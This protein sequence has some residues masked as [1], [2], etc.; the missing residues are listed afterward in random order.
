MSISRRDV[1]AAGAI[2]AALGSS[3]TSA[4]SPPAFREL[5]LPNKFFAAIAKG[6]L[7]EARKSAH[8]SISLAVVSTAGTQ[9]FDGPDAVTEALNRFLRIEGFAMIGDSSLAQD[10]YGGMYWRDLG[11]WL[12][13]DMLKG[14]AIEVGSCDDALS[15][16]VFNVFVNIDSATEKLRTILLL[17]NRNLIAQLGN[18]GDT[19][20]FDK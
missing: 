16:G 1:F 15:H 8:P 13:N 9:M 3:A 2:F 10:A 14:D 17:E 12:C 6:A 7:A 18:W 20:E 11:P 4:C 5:D 19:R